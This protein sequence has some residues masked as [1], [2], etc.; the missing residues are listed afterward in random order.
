MQLFVSLNY[1]YSGV[2]K[3]AFNFMSPGYY[4]IFLP[5]VILF[6]EFYRKDLDKQIKILLLMSYSP[7]TARVP[8]EELS[9]ITL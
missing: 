1:G 4:I 6:V 7:I 9:E 8:Y 3:M 2:M 5:V